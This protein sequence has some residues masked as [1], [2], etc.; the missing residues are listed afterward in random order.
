L[1][2]AYVAAQRSG[3]W[4]KFEI[5]SFDLAMAL[6]GVWLVAQAARGMGGPIGSVLSWAPVRYLGTISYGIYVYHLL[7]IDLLPR[8]ARRAG[9]PD[10]LAGLG[11][12][13]LA[14]FAFYGCMTVVVAAISWHV[15]EAPINRLK[16]RFEYR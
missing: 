9:Y 13:T 4:W 7:L 14:F 10:L 6:V 16:A 3:G 12:E 11:N 2:I 1:F 15:F 8:L 5:V